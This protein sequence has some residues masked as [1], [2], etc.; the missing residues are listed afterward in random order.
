MEQN[1][2]S[3]LEVEKRYYWKFR[4]IHRKT[5]APEPLTKERLW[6]RCFPVNFGKFLRTPIFYGTSPVA[7]DTAKTRIFWIILEKF[8]SK[9]FLIDLRIVF[10]NCFITRV[11]CERTW[12]RGGQE[13][14]RKR[15]KFT[16]SNKMI[17]RTQTFTYIH[18]SVWEIWLWQWDQKFKNYAS[19]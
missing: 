8:V 2:S 11:I 1:R 4:K 13:V 10:Q 16:T 15:S 19:L 6:N 12:V 3:R 7:V 17:T 14:V 5:P 18:N 9:R